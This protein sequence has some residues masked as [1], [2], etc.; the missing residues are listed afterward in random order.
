MKFTSLAG[1]PIYFN[2]QNV[3]EIDH[4]A[5]YGR[6]VVDDTGHFVEDKGNGGYLF[7]KF[8][9]GTEVHLIN[10]NMRIVREPVE[11]VARWLELDGI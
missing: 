2:R 5:E 7:E 4:L 10:G 9:N 6:N 1:H 3:C 8:E 11:T